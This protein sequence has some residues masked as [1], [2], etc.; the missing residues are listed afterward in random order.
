[1]KK[2]LIV[3]DM[4]NGFLKPGAFLYCG[5]DSRRIIPFVREMVQQYSDAG[6][7]VIFLADNHN[8]GDPEFTVYPPHCLKGTEEACV[9]D[10]LK[11]L[12]RKEILIPKTRF[13]GFYGTDLD[14][15]LEEIKPELVEVVGVCTNICVLYTVE[16][17]RNR[18]YRVKVH[19]KG[20][21]SFDEEAAEFALRQMQ[22]VLGAEIV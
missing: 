4:L 21:A 1:M 7:P 15:I 8:P 17:L 6:N 13:S 9:I 2:V 16:G 5:D 12:A 11:D 10:E 18:D 19:R 14:K 22:T 20:V 3:V